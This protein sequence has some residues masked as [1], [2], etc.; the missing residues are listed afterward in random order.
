MAIVQS[1]YQCARCESEIV[2]I[3]TTVEC[4]ACG[5]PLGKYHDDPYT[6]PLTFTEQHIKHRDT[7]RFVT[8]LSE[9]SV[10]KANSIINDALS[11]MESIGGKKCEISGIRTMIEMSVRIGEIAKAYDAFLQA[12]GK[13]IPSY[14]LTPTTPIVTGDTNEHLQKAG[15]REETTPGS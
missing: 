9:L 14:Y 13:H 7:K 10:E 3:S 11:V 8:V 6:P 4:P 15:A 2:A 1:I 5:L 12:G